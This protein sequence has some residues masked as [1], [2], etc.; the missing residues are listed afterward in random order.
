MGEGD[1]SVGRGDVGSDGEAAGAAP[2]R[3]RVQ[4]LVCSSRRLPPAMWAPALLRAC[5]RHRSFKRASRF[6]TR[7]TCMQWEL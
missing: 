2:G 1:D 3:H 6:Y 7:N 4:G 5:S